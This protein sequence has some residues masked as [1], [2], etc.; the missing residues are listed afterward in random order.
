MATAASLPLIVLYGPTPPTEFVPNTKHF[1]PMSV[2]EFGFASL[3]KLPVDT[4]HDRIRLVL[5]KENRTIYS[6]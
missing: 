5:E 6:R 2:Q 1:Y 3:D 4:V